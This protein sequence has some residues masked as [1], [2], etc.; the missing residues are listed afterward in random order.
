MNMEGHNYLLCGPNCDIC[1]ENSRKVFRDILENEGFLE[2]KR[3]E[4]KDR[5][6]SY[7]YVETE[8]PGKNGEKT[9]L[10][11]YAWITVNPKPDV[12]LED[13]TKIIHKMYSK[14][15]ITGSLY[16]FEIGGKN[17]HQHS[18]GVIKFNYR[19]DKVLKELKNTV[20]N[21][22]NVDSNNCFCLRFLND[23]KHVLQKIEYMQGQK[24]EDKMDAVDASQ[25]WRSDNELAE[26]Y[27]DPTL[28]T[29]IN[30]VII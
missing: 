10:A 20:K 13:F 1:F 23:E 29:P 24:T 19:K 2:Y 9:N 17:Q 16:I 18:H 30:N 27:G 22:C 15:W 4:L 28:V 11:N 8:N 25:Q 21:I 14:K 7:D 12:N 26:Y 3:P 6:S 5:S